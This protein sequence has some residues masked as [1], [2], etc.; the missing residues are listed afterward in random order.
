MQSLGRFSHR[1]HTSRDQNLILRVGIQS[2]K[3]LE[4]IPVFLILYRQR[5]MVLYHLQ[6]Y[7]LL[8]FTDAEY[9]ILSEIYGYL[10]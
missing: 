4:E 7:F 10:A 5:L 6:E 3:S 1:Y 2:E 9:P 8:F